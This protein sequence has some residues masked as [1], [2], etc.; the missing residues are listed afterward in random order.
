MGQPL[1]RTVVVNNP[2]GVHARPADLIA[3]CARGFESNV[4]LAKGTERIDAKSIWGILTLAATQGTQ[5]EIQAEGRDAAE[6]L[7]AL[8]ELIAS[9]FTE[10]A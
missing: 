10:G 7:D 4:T 6:A 2:N 1:C 9:N 3:K 8:A 5:L